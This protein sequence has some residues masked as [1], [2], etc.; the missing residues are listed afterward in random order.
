MFHFL[1]F[2]IIT[3]GTTPHS[4]KKERRGVVRGPDYLEGQF[5]T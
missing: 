3:P 5:K 1:K 2:Y 4:F